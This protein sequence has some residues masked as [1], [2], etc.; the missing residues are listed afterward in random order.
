[1]PRPLEATVDL[2]A[3]RNNLGVAQRHAKGARVL[4]VVKADAYGHGLDRILPGLKDAT[5]F[6]VIELESAL[7]LRAAHA[8]RPVLLLEGFFDERELAEI[9]AAGLQTVIHEQSQLEMLLSASLPKPVDVF[10][11]INT[12][13]NRLG[14][15]IGKCAEIIDRLAASANVRETVL[16]THFADADGERGVEWQLG[17]F[18]KLA[19]SSGLK[20]CAANSAA[21][22]RYPQTHGAWVRPGIMLYG[23]SPFSDQSAAD[24]GLRPVVTVR[25]RIIGVQAL[26][27]GDAVGYGCTYV[28]KEPTRIGIVAAGYGDGYPRH[29]PSGT[30]V[31]VNGERVP[32]VGRIS[33]D[34]LCVDLASVPQAGVDSPVTLWGEGLPV[35]EV[36]HSAGTVS[37]ELLTKLTRRVPFKVSP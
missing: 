11:K 17:P 15:T 36:A 20:M 7:R 10:M 3:L 26:V 2:Q 32:T 25:S 31:L 33:M 19:E 21:V 28:A 18:Q 37:Y 12:G 4:A 14:F 9:S 23:A 6:A 5:G 34:T 24:L 30:P 16:M 8:G 13:M 27:P 1:M 22:L 35:E 29:A